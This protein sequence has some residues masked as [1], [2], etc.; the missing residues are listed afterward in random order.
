MNP[1]ASLLKFIFFLTLGI[2]FIIAGIFKWSFPSIK[3]W[4]RATKY[5]ELLNTIG[6][7]LFGVWIVSLAMDYFFN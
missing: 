1:D 3:P 7:V 4:W 5:G 2:I 6:M